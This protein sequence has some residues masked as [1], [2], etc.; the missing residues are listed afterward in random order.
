VTKGKGQRTGQLS[1]LSQDKIEETEETNLELADSKFLLRP[2]PALPQMPDGFGS[3]PDRH[4]F[5]LG[6]V[7]LDE[8]GVGHADLERGD[9]L[10][11]H[12]GQ[13]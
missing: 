7:P 5:D 8:L 11:R 13:T 1:F 12:L 10:L 9:G 6:S 2:A 4:V 3:R